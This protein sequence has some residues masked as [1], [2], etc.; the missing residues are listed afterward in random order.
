MKNK[1]HSSVLFDLQQYSFQD[2]QPTAIQSLSEKHTNKA[3]SVNICWKWFRCERDLI[4]T[5]WGK[6]PVLLIVLRELFVYS[7]IVLNNLWFSN[8][9]WMEF[10][11]QPLQ[12]NL[13]AP[14]LDVYIAL[15]QINILQ[16]WHHRMQKNV[17]IKSFLVK[18]LNLL[19]SK[20]SF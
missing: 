13:L 10:R 3:A 2:Q 5:T 15:K 9:H 11:I 6:R 4:F 20:L 17:D 1:I 7:F 12:R 16:R 18:L 19:Q 14:L 8:S